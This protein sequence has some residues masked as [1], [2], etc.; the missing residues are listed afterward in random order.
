MWYIS[1]PFVVIIE[2]ANLTQA[3]EKNLVGSLHACNDASKKLSPP[4]FHLNKWKSIKRQRREKKVASLQIKKVFR[5]PFVGKS[6]PTPSK[7]QH[8]KSEQTSLLAK[9]SRSILLCSLAPYL[10]RENIARTH[11]VLFFM[12]R[13]RNVPYGLERLTHT[14]E[15]KGWIHYH[16]CA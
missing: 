8:R 14:S 3:R 7:N 11:S 2:R 15:R 10:A 1:S 16:A 4:I 6:G 12:L 5:T 9:G 13:R